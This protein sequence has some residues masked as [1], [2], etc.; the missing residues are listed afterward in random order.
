MKERLRYALI[1]DT[2]TTG[3]DPEEH[4]LIEIAVTLFDLECAQPV[5]SFASL[6]RCDHNE[7]EDVNGIPINMLARAPDLGDVW[8]TVKHMF[9]I[10]VGSQVIAPQVV[11]AHNAEFDQQFVPK[12]GLPWVCSEEDIK[13]P[14][15]QARGGSL[16]NLALSLGL[17]VA[18]AHRAM[19]D[20]DTLCRIF[21]RLAELGHDLP[22]L[23]QHAMRPKALFYA[24]VPFAKKDLAKEH[25]FRWDPEKKQWWRRMAIDDAAD[26]PFKTKR[27][28]TP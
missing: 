24:L 18:S 23:I 28:K 4:E 10:Q 27:G 17:G 2:E 20:V 7:A 14:H 16:V 19:A 3:F 22:Q 13:W 6:I 21:T 12:H 25:G 26:L 9:R 8:A 1:L 15:R 5:Q 11:I